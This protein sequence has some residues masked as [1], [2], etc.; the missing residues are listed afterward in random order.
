MPY[1]AAIPWPHGLAQPGK[2]VARAL[3]GQG[4]R[5]PLARSAASLP[6]CLGG[7]LAAPPL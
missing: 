7:L 6:R 4:S 2:Q 5:W 1:R 3:A